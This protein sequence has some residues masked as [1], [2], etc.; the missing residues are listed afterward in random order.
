MVATVLLALPVGFA[1]QGG[2]G[3]RGAPLGSAVVLVGGYLLAPVSWLEAVR[4]SPPK[5][6]FGTILALSV[7]YGLLA[8]AVQWAW[9]RR[10]S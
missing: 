5:W 1:T 4:G 6:G 7:A 3:W 10:H 2:V 9:A 8:L